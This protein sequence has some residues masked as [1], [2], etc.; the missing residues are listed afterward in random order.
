MRDKESKRKLYERE[1]KENKMC[2]YGLKEKKY[3]NIL[4]KN[5][6]SLLTVFF[7]V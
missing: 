3:K 6:K 1:N 5:N 4:L 2:Y 7:F